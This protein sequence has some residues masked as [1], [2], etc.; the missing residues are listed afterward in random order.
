MSV[1]INFDVVSVAN[2][3]VK[4]VLN[5]DTTRDLLP[6]RHR[7]EGEVVNVTLLMGLICVQLCNVGELPKTS[8]R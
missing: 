3:L 8:R 4:S 6:H 5:D 7:I 1:D 2:A